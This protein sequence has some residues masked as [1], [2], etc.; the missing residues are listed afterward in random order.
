M[1]KNKGWTLVELI[2]VVMIIGV[3]SLGIPQLVSQIYK[4]YRINTLNIELQDEARTIMDFI[5][6]DLRQ[7]RSS[8]ITIDSLSGQPYYS[9]INFL[10]IQGS[11]VSYYQDGRHLIRIYGSH[12]KTLTKNL[13]YLAFAFPQSYD[14]GLVSVAFTLEKYLYQFQYKALHMASEKI[15]VMND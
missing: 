10:T 11:S 15:R 12:R 8:T 9:R 1:V 6:R 14:M 2:I 4:Y 5:S 3:I 13:Y 7:A